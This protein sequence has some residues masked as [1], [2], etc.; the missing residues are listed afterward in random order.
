ML[1]PDGGTLVGI[2]LVRTG[3]EPSG[4]R[5]TAGL[6]GSFVVHAWAV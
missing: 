4:V 3:T 2:V 5:L 6:V 1:D